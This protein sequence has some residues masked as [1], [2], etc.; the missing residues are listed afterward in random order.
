MPKSSEIGNDSG[1]DELSSL[2]AKEVL[3]VLAQYDEVVKE[4]SSI[5]SRMETGNIAPADVPSPARQQAIHDDLTVLASGFVHRLA[6]EAAL[7][8]NPGIC[9]ASSLMARTEGAHRAAAPETQGPLHDL[10]STRLQDWAGQA[11]GPTYLEQHFGIPRSTLHWW[12]RHN[13]VVA[14]RKGARKHVFPLAQFIDG[15]PAPGIRQVLAS[16]TSPRLA[17]FWLIRPSPH[18]DG[19]VPIEMLRQDLTEEVVLAAHDFAST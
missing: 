3:R 9:E 19:R 10:E 12:Q 18:L 7:R 6:T 4:F 13:D 11:A 5:E 1:L 14:L 8:F 15:R 2:V 16:I 17:W